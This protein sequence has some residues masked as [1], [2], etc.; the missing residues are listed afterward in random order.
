M[1]RGALVALS[2]RYAAEAAAEDRSGERLRWAAREES[3]GDGLVGRR[4]LW[5]GHHEDPK[6]GAA[7]L[8]DGEEPGAEAGA[9]TCGAQTWSL[10]RQASRH[11]KG[12][13][14]CLQIRTGRIFCPNSA[15]LLLYVCAETGS[16]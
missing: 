13:F 5:Q 9:H 16:S 15:C 4:L 12:H 7:D 10:R 8:G 11:L 1:W 14:K 3:H 6:A 2:V